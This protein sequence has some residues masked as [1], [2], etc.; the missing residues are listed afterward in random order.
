MINFRK[1]TQ[2]DVPLITKIY[3]QNI[4]K[5][6]VTADLKP[7]S[8]EDMLGA[9]KSHNDKRLFWMI[10]MDHKSVGWVS[11]ESFYGRPAYHSTVEISIYIDNHY[12]HRGI[13][14]STLK[15]INQQTQRLNIHTILA[16]IFSVNRPSQK[17]FKAM[18]YQQYG[19][20]PKV[21]DMK[22]KLISL[23]ILGK[24]F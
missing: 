16:F 21:A 3:N 9:L 2:K 15:L 12:Q 18:G 5:R 23:D 6:T 13:G 10:V 20:L 1:A 14:T 22:G 24:K 4:P 17:L 8:D 7:A 19:H 11:L